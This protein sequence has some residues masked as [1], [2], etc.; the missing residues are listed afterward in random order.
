MERD[1]LGLTGLPRPPA[2]APTAGSSGRGPWRS[3]KE[4]RDGRDKVGHVDGLALVRVEPGGHDLLPVLTHH[5]RGH[6]DDGNPARGLLGSEPSEGLDSVNPR[7]P[8]VHQDQAWAPLSGKLDALFA[9]L[10]LDGGVALERQ[11]VPD[12]LPVLVVVLDDQDQ[13]AGHGLTGSVKV[14]VEPTPTWLVTEIRPPCSSTNLR[15]RASPSPVPSAFLSAVP[16]CRNSSN[17]VS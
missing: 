7:Q 5:R 8:N 12:E 2:P 4:L 16:T 14:N 13:L 17:T 3:C 9:R 10:G 1:S 6:G 11:H 15:E